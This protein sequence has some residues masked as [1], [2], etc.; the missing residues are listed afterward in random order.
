MCYKREVMILL[1]D[2]YDSFT[3]NLVHL[4]GDISLETR[5]V[6]NDALSVKEAIDLEPRA[7]ILS[8]GPKD[9][10][11]AGICLDLV[12]ESNGRIPIF[13]VCLGFQVIAQA[14]GAN[15]I[16]GP[17]PVHGKLDIIQHDGGDIFENIEGS[18]EA[19]RYHS[20]IVDA[21][22]LPSQL[23]ATARNKDG[24]LMALR[25][26]EFPLFGVQFHPESIASQYGRQILSNFAAIAGIN[27]HAPI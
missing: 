27:I 12:R 5:V 8:P 4:L 16:R 17:E 13:G 3:Y 20:L 7:V 21:E 24:I 1:I 11:H 10:D 14:F 19:T 18:F 25:H 22:N 15:I 6:R 9:P 23:V 2:N 26:R